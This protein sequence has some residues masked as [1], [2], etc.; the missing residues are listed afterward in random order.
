L[1]EEHEKQQGPLGD[2]RI[3]LDKGETI[4]KFMLEGRQFWTL[5]IAGQKAGRIMNEKMSLSPNIDRKTTKHTQTTK[6]QPSADQ[7]YL[8]D[9]SYLG[10][11]AIQHD[12]TACTNDRHR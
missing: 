7:Q 8:S 9:P 5:V 10:F 1:S 11:I 4:L 2:M 12:V 3:S 6:Q